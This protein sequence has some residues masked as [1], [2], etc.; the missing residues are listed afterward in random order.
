[1]TTSTADLLVELNGY[2]VAAGSKPLKRWSES[3]AKLDAAIENGRKLYPSPATV[4]AS[5]DEIEDA[6]RKLAAAND[7]D[8]AP[9]TETKK[10]SPK[11]AKAD[12]TGTRT[13]PELCRAVGK[14]EKVGRAKCRRHGT[15]LRPL[16]L[17]PKP[18]G[19]DQE[20]RFSL[21]NLAKVC[22]ILDWEAPADWVAPS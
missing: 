4:T 5:L 20:W 2:R 11:P 12:T 15:K 16:M 19:Q 14:K 8:A 10:K 18:L 1:M 3:R 6:S 7:A 9:K 22:S 13:I 17:E 21:T